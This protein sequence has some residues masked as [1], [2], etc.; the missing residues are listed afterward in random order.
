MAKST[1]YLISVVVPLFNEEAGLTHF[2]DDLIAELDKISGYN[3]E[4]IYCDDGS[5]DSTPRLLKQITAAS[6]FVRV[7]RLTRNF[8]KEMATTAGIIAA[9]G[10]AIITIDGDGQHPVSYIPQFIEKWRQ[11][12]KV[13]IGQRIEDAHATIVKRT[14]SQG[15][16]RIINRFSRYQ[17]VP[18]STDYRLIDKEV[19]RL[20]AGLTEHNRITR[21]LI[22]W[23]GY[24]REYIPFSAKQRT[25]GSASY[26]LSGLV[27]LAIDSII[28][29][30]LSPLY[31]AAL[32][33]AVVL[34]ISVLLGLVMIVNA[35][36]GDPLGWHA[37]GTAY[38]LVFLLFLI[39][40]L[41]V[42]QGIT[43]LYLSHIYSETQN[44]PLYIIDHESSIRL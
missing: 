25:H 13:V 30:S 27:K 44:R 2:H 12:H 36:A 6:S 43:G 3:F 39:G 23:L 31:L 19:Q 22:D 21:G 34:P 11:G 5:V 8:G 16:Y 1:P 33:G 40:L 42:S 18:R 24:H 14:G 38:V 29:S 10:D 4:V 15:F 7:I 17:M 37:T 41:M 20:F 9:K 26:S 32:V 28:S 35:G